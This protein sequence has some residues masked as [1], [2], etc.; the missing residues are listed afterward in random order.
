MSDDV[1][2]YPRLVVRDADAALAFYTRA[3]GAEVTE[4]Y[5]APGG[6][7][8]HA[9]LRVGG[10]GFAVKEAD[11]VDPAPTD[12]SVPVIMAWYVPD[13]DAAAARMVDAGAEALVPVTDH[14]YGDRAGR[15][16]DPFGHLWM[17]AQRIGDRPGT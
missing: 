13:A 17:V 3:F 12:G 4:R 16:R 1:E 15:L 6:S 10:V 8:V 14:E 5:A 9:M 11:A 7:V 2:M